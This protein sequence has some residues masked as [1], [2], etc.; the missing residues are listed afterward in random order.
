PPD[1]IA[2]PRRGLEIEIRGGGFH[3]ARQRLYPR[4]D[5]LVRQIFG[6]GGGPDLHAVRAFKDA[7]KDVGDILF[8]AL[9]RD[10][11]LRVIDLLLLAAA[12]GFI[13][14]GAH[15]AGDAVCVKDG[16]AF[17]VPRRAAD[18]LDQRGARA[19]VSFLV[20]VQDGDQRAFG[21]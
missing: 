8:D 16:A 12:G 6:V 13:D 11:V 15:A 19:Q 4:A 2:Q 10:A 17:Y 1:F 21:D 14:G 3:F 7:L 20:R 18:G 5:I 9:R